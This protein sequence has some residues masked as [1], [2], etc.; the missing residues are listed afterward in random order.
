MKKLFIL[1]F[2]FFIAC[3]APL[4]SQ[5]KGWVEFYNKINKENKDI[6]KIQ[7]Q[8]NVSTKTPIAEH[9]HWFWGVWALISRPYS[10]SYISIIVPME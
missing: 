9:E 3:I 8:I 4:V 1:S 7:P 2:L 6:I 5:T 10:E